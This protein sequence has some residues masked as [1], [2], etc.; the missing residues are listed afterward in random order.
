MKQHCLQQGGRGVAVMQSGSGLSA[1]C[2]L[3]RGGGILF[4]LL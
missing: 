2:C 4:N 1:G 3:I